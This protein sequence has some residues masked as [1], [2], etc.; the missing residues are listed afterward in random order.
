MSW[1]LGEV[2][3]GWTAAEVSKARPHQA[4]WDQR[5]RTFLKVVCGG[6]T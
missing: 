4:L 6:E 5:A 2:E 3:C 1:E